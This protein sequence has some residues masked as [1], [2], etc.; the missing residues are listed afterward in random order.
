MYGRDDLEWDEL[1]LAGLRILKRRAVGRN[2]IQYADFVA[3]LADESGQPPLTLSRDRAAI[4]PLLA[5]ISERAREDH[6]GLLISVLVYNKASSMP[7]KGFFELTKRLGLLSADASEKEE[8]AFMASQ[9]TGLDSHY[10]GAG[11]R[12]AAARNPE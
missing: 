6:P 5:E 7:G 4:G 1:V 9:T 10:S 8:W 2:M 3:A 11:S 12:A